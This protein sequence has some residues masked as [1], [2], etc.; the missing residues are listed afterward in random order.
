[1]APD[2]PVA[3]LGVT[4]SPEGKARVCFN[5]FFLFLFFTTAVERTKLKPGLLIKQERDGY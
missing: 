5:A 4:S 3:C 2:H 1:M